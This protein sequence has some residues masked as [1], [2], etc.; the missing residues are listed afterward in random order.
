MAKAAG[1]RYSLHPRPMPLLDSAAL[2]KRQERVSRMGGIVST[3]RKRR[4]MPDVATSAAARRPG[5]GSAADRR[6]LASCRL[7]LTPAPRGFSQAWT[8]LNGGAECAD[9]NARTS[10]ATGTGHLSVA[11]ILG[12]LGANR[13]HVC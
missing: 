12:R 2:E 3:S 8:G 11:P 7:A 4:R 6:R 9:R 1:N 13:V 5:S 10:V